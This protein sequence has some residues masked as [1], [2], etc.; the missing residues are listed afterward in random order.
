MNNFGIIKSKLEKASTDLFGKKKF[1]NFMKDFKTNILE[2]KDVSEI[3]YIYD[4]LSS[5]KGLS[6]DI[7]DDY[8]N[9]SIEYCQILIESNKKTLSN[10]DKWVSNFVNETENKYFNIDT[11]IYSKSIKDLENVLE[12]K[13]QVLNTIIKE[14][15]VKEKIESINLPIS[16]MV[17]VAEENIKSEL[18]TLSESEKNELQSIVNLSKEELE[19]EFKE[20]QEGVINNLKMS[21][22]ESKE[23]DMKNMIEKTIEKISESKTTHYD[24][25]KLRKLKSGL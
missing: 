3:F 4:D 22:N 13:R 11:I 15:E 16:T 21:L 19:K 10:V 17:K 20:L 7:A 14:N 24:L 9:E 18:N 25:Y 23:S 5:K 6:K 1:S 2:N 8:L 12:S